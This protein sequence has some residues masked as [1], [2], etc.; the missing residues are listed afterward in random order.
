M[1]ETTRR[2]ETPSAVLS[3][4]RAG[5]GPAVLFIQGVGVIGDGW[6]PQCEGLCDRY[7]T[8]AFDNRGLGESTLRSGPVTI[9]A[10]ALDALAIMDAETIERFHVVGHSMGGLIAQEVA[11][12]APARVKSLALLC[13][14]ARG[15]QA[16]RLTADIVLIGLRT[17]IGTRAMRR[18]AFLELVMPPALLAEGDRARLAETLRPLFGRDLAEQPP[19]IMKQLRATAKYDASGRLGQLAPI[20]S[21]VVSAELDRIALPAFG[22]ELAAAIPGARLVEIPGAGHGVPIHSPE[23]VNA[24]LAEHFASAD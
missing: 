16:A 21:L 13:T 17:R 11:L 14:F 1:T 9:E 2:L 23:K 24:L 4:R 22:R 19:I 18:S 12:R 10:M 3:Y 7:T 6:R 5:S 20:P 8:I 15:K